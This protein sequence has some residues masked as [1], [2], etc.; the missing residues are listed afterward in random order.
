M[1]E[2]VI[3]KDHAG[4]ST[5]ES[6]Y[7]AKAIFGVEKMIVVTQSYHL[8][9]SLYLAKDRGIEA[10]GVS[11]DVRTYYGQGMRDLRE[12]VA[13]NKDFLYC[14]FDP[15]PTYLGDPIEIK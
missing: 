11:A 14:L 2:E 5:Y 7:R 9:R 8:Y 13:R 4:F 10:L 12:I 15:E 3:Y 6:M 1:P